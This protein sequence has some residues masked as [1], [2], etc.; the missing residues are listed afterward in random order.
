MAIISSRIVIGDDLDDPILVFK[1]ED[2]T[3][4]SIDTDA[5]VSLVGEELYIDQFTA[6]V[7]YYVWSPYVINPADLYEEVGP[8]SGVVVSFET[9]HTGSVHDGDIIIKPIQDFNGY[10]R[11]WAPGC[12]KNLIDPA[13]ILY[14]Y[15]ISDTGDYIEDGVSC[16]SAII[17]AIPG[18]TYTFSGIFTE[19]DDSDIKRIHGYVGDRW[20]ELIDTLEIST[21]G[22]YSI[23]FTI[24]EGCNGFLVSSYDSDEEKM[25]ERG[26]TVTSYE[27]YSNICRIDGWRDVR[28]YVS[29]TG[30][31]EDATVYEV[32]LDR[33]VYGGRLNLKTGLLTVTDGNIL[34]Y[35]D[36]E[37]NGEWISDRDVYIPGTLP[38]VGAQVVYKLTYPFT[39]KTIDLNI[40]TLSGDN[41]IWTNAGSISDFVA[42][43]STGVIHD[44]FVSS[45]GYILC[46]KKNYD[47]RFIPYG[48]KITYYTDNV[49][50]G[51]FYVKTV[52]RIGT[53][54]YK[55][56]AVS[57]IGLLDKQYHT[58]GIYQGQFITE[59][60]DEILGDDY[61]YIVDGVVAAQRVY[62]WLPYDTKRNNLYQILLAYGVE[63]ILGDNGSMFF[64]FPE[65]EQPIEIPASRVFSGGTVIYDEPASKLEL[66]EHSYHYDSNVDEVTL[67]DNTRD[68]MAEYM[69]VKFDEPIVP[70][71]IRTD[72]FTIHSYG[73]N[74]AIIT[75]NGVLY[76]KPYVHNIRVLTSENEDAQTEKVVAVENATLIS[77]ANADNALA[78]LSEYY[79][80]VYSVEQDIEVQ[81]EKPGHLYT[82]E[83]PFHENMTGYITRM[84][85]S[86]SSFARATCRFIQN[87]TPTGIGQAYTNRVLI[88]LGAGAIETWTIPEEV[89]E[90]E[91]PLIRVTLIGRGH[92]GTKGTNGKRG[93]SSDAYQKGTGGEGGE[94]GK[95]GI[96][97]NIL[98][99]TIYADDLTELTFYNSG[100]NS[101]MES[102]KYN[103]SS[104]SGAPNNYGYFDIFTGELFAYPGKDGLPGAAGGDGDLYTHSTGTPPTSTPGQDLTYGNI[105]KHGGAVSRRAIYTGGEIGVAVSMS[106]YVSSAG[107]GGAA[108]GKNGSAAWGKEHSFN[109]HGRGGD[110]ADAAVPENPPLMYGVGGNGGHGGAGSGA[111]CMREWWNSDYSKVIATDYIQSGGGGSASSGNAGSYGCAIIYY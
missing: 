66:S 102:T 16:C 71:T 94:G 87:Y 34:S 72:N 86:I 90:K 74:Y 40:K 101:V 100:S 15:Y 64:T 18:E 97:G 108:Y 88:P 75:G 62:G 52:E 50:S 19:E 59:L 10:D 44:A 47:I 67:Y 4:V 58:G 89:F 98:T 78:R 60:I 103:Y 43:V 55:I 65:A 69:F 95:G 5:S 49:V 105:T 80:H 14:G 17:P 27:P 110:G 83:N 26:D 68:E 31:V 57:A 30:E 24:P 25:I 12:G 33:V 85:K 1:S 48:T 61:E 28:A 23:T 36:E 46:S 11:P 38:S 81:T 82:T 104:A 13:E 21:V 93:L 63:I 37:I 70:S 29:P 22:P 41:Y 7:D 77:F 92:N 51:I 96:G 111:G 84:T 54:F 6:S 39:I 91:I 53:E 3:I 56:S 2:N 20:H 107:G 76:G 109:G 79:F 32:N 42:A 99:I 106:V 9:E 45:D 8:F 35:I 73:T